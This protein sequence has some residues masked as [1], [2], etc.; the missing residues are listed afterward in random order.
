MRTT[1][2]IEDGIAR[3][4]KNI[5]RRSR[6]SFKAVVNDALRAGLEGDR[7][8]ASAK[9][10]RVEPVALGGVVGE[11]GLDQALRVADQLEDLEFAREIQLTK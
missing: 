11:H 9:T 6:R 7:I 2:T 10:Y 3:Q 4:L 5:A 1:L 8:T